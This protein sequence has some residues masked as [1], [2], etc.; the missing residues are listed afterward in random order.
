M[1]RASYLKKAEEH[2][3]FAMDAPDYAD[4]AAWMRL[5]EPH[6]AQSAD[7]PPEHLELDT[8]GRSRGTRQEPSGST[9]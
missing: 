2:A 4:H 8:H 9:H 5:A 1:D 6:M 3:Q 7:H